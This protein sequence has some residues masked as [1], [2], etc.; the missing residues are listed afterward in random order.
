MGFMATH[1]K[2]LLL[3]AALAAGAGAPVGGAMAA[4]VQVIGLTA[5]KAVVVINGAKPRTLSA[6]ESTPDGVKL[7]SATSDSAVFE[8]GG[9]RQTLTM[10]QSG[11]FVAGSSAPAGRQSAILTADSR[12]HFVTTGQIN[13]ISV[14]MLVDTGASLVSMSAAEAKRVGVNYLEGKPTYVQTANGVAPVY[15]VKLDSVRVGDI[16]LN[17]V[18]G[19]VHV[20]DGL[21][22]TLLGMSFLNR[23]EMQRDGDRMTL[24]KRY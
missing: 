15:R 17:N 18:D 9:K 4:D 1:C 22:I 5:G 24:N 21:P 13:G 20:G 7:V 16:T 11:H 2:A 3:V 8:I 6:G 14:R 19:M 12:G 23:M 10:G